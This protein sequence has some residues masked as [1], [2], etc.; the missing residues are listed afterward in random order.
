MN[1]RSGPLRTGGPLTGVPVTGNRPY[2]APRCV[3][4]PP[5]TGR[6]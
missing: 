3:T 2:T 6:A 5:D 1:R 4:F